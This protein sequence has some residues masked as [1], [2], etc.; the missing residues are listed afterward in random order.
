MPEI[1]LGQIV[2]TTPADS[3][4]LYRELRTAYRRA[5]ARGESVA[6]IIEALRVVL[7]VSR[8]DAVL[9]A[10]LPNGEPY[11]FDTATGSVKPKR[12]REHAP[13][14]KAQAG[15]WPGHEPKR[16]PMH[17]MRASVV[18]ACPRCAI[19]FVRRTEARTMAALDSPQPDNKTETP[20]RQ[21][22]S[23]RTYGSPAQGR[24][25]WLCITC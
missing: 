5:V 8:Q 19:E 22:F 14:K 18:H 3:P 10:T 24:C 17:Q 15:I 21:T 1:K 16:C 13:T 25:D 4:D 2:V 6:G 12:I 9:T 7:I 11:T 20:S 23:Q